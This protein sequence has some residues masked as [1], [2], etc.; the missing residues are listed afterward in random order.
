MKTVDLFSG[1]GGM[2]LGLMR[3][4]FDVVLAM[5]AWNLA[6][7]TYN[8]NLPPHAMQ[9]DL[10][11]SDA[12]ISFIREFGVPDMI[13]GGPPCTDFSSAGKRREGHR[14]DLTVSFARIVSSLKPNLFLMENVPLTA[15][16][17]S[18]AQ[19]RE[20]LR[21]A[22][23]GLS[24][25]ILNASLC[26]VPQKR[27]RLFLVG[28][29]HGGD[30]EFVPHLMPREKTPMSLRRWCEG[31]GMALPF[32]A[33]YRHPRT[34]ARRGVFG[35]DE[36]APTMRGVNRPVPPNY[37]GHPND[38]MPVS[39]VRALRMEERAL[40]QGFPLDWKW[41]GQPLC[42][43]KGGKTAA[44][45]MIGNAVPVGLA[46]WVGKAIRITLMTHAQRQD[47]SILATLG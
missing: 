14:A 38:A 24:Q 21:G 1:A 8:A 15:K 19:A 16:S 25:V 6:V 27:E 29:L 45:Q 23:Y 28:R 46:E 20:L 33:Y 11:N 47:A 18:F 4:G 9:S 35:V 13:A 30:D 12:A 3:A 42:K 41:P 10:S 44:E 7:E 34:Y 40:I 31:Q 37:K 22:G 32:Q 43:L 26:G 2:S 17:I 39:Q 5:D 36:P